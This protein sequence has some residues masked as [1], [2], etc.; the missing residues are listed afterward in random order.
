M[1][2]T[3]GASNRTARRGIA[4]IGRIRTIATGTSV[5]SSLPGR[6]AFGKW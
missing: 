4:A 2:T 1:R 3:D 5:L 6:H